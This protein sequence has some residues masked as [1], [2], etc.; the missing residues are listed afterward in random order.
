MN[1]YY[2]FFSLKEN[3]IG[4][5]GTKRIIPKDFEELSN[6]MP[7]AF[8]NITF[9]KYQNFPNTSCLVIFYLNDSLY[10]KPYNGISYRQAIESNGGYD[11]GVEYCGYIELPT[12]YSDTISLGRDKKIN[13]LLI[14][15]FDIF[16]V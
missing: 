9:D 10:L 6:Y 8:K 5:Q 2:S 13:D 4:I 3:L 7:M 16:L 15:T 1:K 14:E 12:V 11:F